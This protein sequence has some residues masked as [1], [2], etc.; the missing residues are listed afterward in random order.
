[1]SPCTY[2]WCSN[3]SICLQLS[4]KDSETRH[5]K[6][7]TNGCYI[8]LKS[9][10]FPLSL[11]FFCFSV[12]VAICSE[13]FINTKVNS[14]ASIYWLYYYYTLSNIFTGKKTVF[15]YFAF[16]LCMFSVLGSDRHV[17]HCFLC[18]FFSL[19]S[20]RSSVLFV[21]HTLTR[22]RTK[23]LRNSFSFR[24]IFFNI[25]GHDFTQITLAHAHHQLSNQPNT[26]RNRKKKHYAER[27]N[28]TKQKW[29]NRKK[30]INK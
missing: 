20:C 19:F 18:S 29:K 30:K 13:K 10:S 23:H 26:S 12:V 5:K 25:Q 2:A 9:L 27:R 1:M 3:V 16:C 15:Y 24:Y 4:H 21:K 28:E 7:N 11:R 6:T 14:G 17:I 8:V 22:N